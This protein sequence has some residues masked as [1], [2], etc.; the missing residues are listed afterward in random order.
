MDHE[1]ERVAQ[2]VTS[3]VPTARPQDTVRDTLAGLHGCAFDSVRSVYVL[4]EAGRL[5]GT[6]ALTDAL[7]R[8]QD[9]ALAELM[10]PDPPSAPQDMDREDAAS[11]AIREGLAAV[12]V[13]DAKGAFLGIFPPRAIMDVLRQEHLEDLHHMVGIWQHTERARQALLSPPLGRARYRLPWLI[14]GL[15][16]SMLATTLVAQ[17]EHTLKAQIAV[18]FFIPAIV[19]LA[20]AVGTQ[21][22]AV[23]VRGISL[24]KAR[25][26]R[27]LAGELTVGLVMGLTLA[28]LTG[29]FAAVTYS[30]VDLALAVAAA[31][32]FASAVATSIGLFLPW[33]FSQ[34]GWDP[35][36]GSGPIATIIQ[37][38]LSLVIY[39]AAVT[40][41]L[42]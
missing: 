42:G 29:L 36:L 40:A 33:L 10:E 4:D 30:Q 26:G 1:F 32:L 38:V 7:A 28:I 11:L 3:R 39:F 22:E 17:F 8:P 14:V 24:T 41:I 25:I 21:S 5:A 19:Y 9:V 15:V 31:V 23:A 27:L 20:D 12:P 37:D 35:A 6:V 34:A 16:G 2:Y 13:V 18:A